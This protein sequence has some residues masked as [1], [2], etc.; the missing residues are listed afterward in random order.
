MLL[1]AGRDKGTTRL[2]E[3]GHQLLRGYKSLDLEYRG[4]PLI[5]ELIDRL[6]ASGA[7]DPIWVAGPEKLCREVFAAQGAAWNE[8]VRV[9]DTDGGFGD[10]LR[11]GV[12][13]ARQAHPGQYLGVMTSDVLPD[14]SELTE[15]IEDFR[16]HSPLNFWM[17]EIPI[18]KDLGALGQSAWKPK[19][20]VRP[21]GESE[22][23]PVLPGHLVIVDPP[24]IRLHL[25]YK[26]FDLAYRTRNRS[27]ADRWWDIV[28]G[29]LGVLL[30]ED[31]RRLLRG[32][33]PASPAMV[34][35]GLYLGRRLRRGSVEQEVLEERLD[36]IWSDDRHRRRHPER[37]GRVALLDALSLA[38]DIDTVE[39]ARE[40][41]AS[42]EDPAPA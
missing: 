25:I 6:R 41:M 32:R 24:V 1:L 15:A 17:S 20:H 16:S 12:E 30:G 11:N 18:P 29:A 36:K 27:V 21:R 4:R 34:Y 2:P 26:I 8:G 42:D 9:A 14:A 3:D 23:L 5:V 22:I 7:F 35:H 39:E 19:Y 28:R 13:A 10:N 33:L 38:R 40:L 31:L 37:Q